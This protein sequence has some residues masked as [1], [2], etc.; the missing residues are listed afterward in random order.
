MVANAQ[1]VCDNGESGIDR[2]AGNEEGTVHNVEIVHVMRATI[3][4]QHRGARVLA[5]FASA[6]L[7]A[8]LC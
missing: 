6:D 2:A 3:E 5:E 7:V 4:V 1:G 8:E